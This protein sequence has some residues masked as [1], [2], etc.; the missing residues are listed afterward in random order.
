MLC[1]F[2]AMNWGLELLPRWNNFP[3]NGRRHLLVQAVVGHFFS[4]PKDSTIPTGPLVLKIRLH[5]VLGFK[6]R[7]NLSH[8]P[9]L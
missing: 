2:S 4:S 8:W 9:W 1:V 6:V 3:S 7:E 5:P